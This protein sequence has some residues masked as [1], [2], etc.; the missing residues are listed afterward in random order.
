[1]LMA[2]FGGAVS[3]FRGV[4]ART[5]VLVGVLGVPA[6]TLLGL[7]GGLIVFKGEL[8]C[9]TR[10]DIAIRWI[11]SALFPTIIISLQHVNKNVF[12]APSAP[13]IETVSAVTIGWTEHSKINEKLKL[14]AA[15]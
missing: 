13:T 12:C 1:M 6:L 15:G 5:V 3:S 2:G 8:D 10:R 9:G 14:V 4:V 11:C 7:A